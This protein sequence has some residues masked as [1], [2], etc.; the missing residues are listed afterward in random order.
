MVK[1]LLK[2]YGLGP[3]WV[4]RDCRVGQ[5]SLSDYLNGLHL[6]GWHTAAQVA[7]LLVAG[8]PEVRE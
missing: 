4:A 3:T 2:R 7:L 5:Q 8:Q 1:C 6:N